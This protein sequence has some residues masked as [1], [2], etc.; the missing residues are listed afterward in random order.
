LPKPLRTHLVEHPF[1]LPVAFL[2]GSLPGLSHIAQGIGRITHSKRARPQR[3]GRR[4]RAARLRASMCGLTLTPTGGTLI[5]KKGNVRL[6]ASDRQQ[7]GVR[8]QHAINFLSLHAHQSPLTAPAPP[9]C[10]DIF[11]ANFSSPCDP[12]PKFSCVPTLNISVQFLTFQGTHPKQLNKG[13]NISFFFPKT[14]DQRVLTRPPSPPCGGPDQC[15]ARCGV[16]Q[17]VYC[18]LARAAPHHTHWAPPRYRPAADRLRCSALLGFGAFPRC[19]YAE[20]TTAQ[21]NTRR[22][23][24]GSTG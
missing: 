12:T 20:V 14:C 5:L 15:A 24:T 2:F 10:L 7:W 8:Q 9:A 18:W 13:A 23:S 22:S 11:A 6:A 19:G 4:G 17:Q 21:K 3:R 1:D 16:Q